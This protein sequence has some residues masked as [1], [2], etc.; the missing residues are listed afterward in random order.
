[1]NVNCARHGGSPP[2]LTGCP[3]SARYLRTPAS[4]TLAGSHLMVIVRSLP[5]TSRMPGLVLIGEA[6]GSNSSIVASAFTNSKS[7]DVPAV[8][9]PAL[10]LPAAACATG[11][12]NT[13][14]GATCVTCWPAIMAEAFL[15]HG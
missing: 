9:V 4:S 1:M 3:A 14:L 2:Y 6:I 10:V 12:R 7:L 8:A 13:L 11:A 15:T 5:V